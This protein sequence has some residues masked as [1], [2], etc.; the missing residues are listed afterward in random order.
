MGRVLGGDPRPNALMAVPFLVLSVLGAVVFF[1]AHDNPVGGLFVGL[2]L[3]YICEFFATLGSALW[4][5]LLGLAHTATGIWLMYLTVAAVL[6]M[7]RGFNL[8]L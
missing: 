4:E 7:A 8:P 6:N 1:G 5:R 2:A 3:V